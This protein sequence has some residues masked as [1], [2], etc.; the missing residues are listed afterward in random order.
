MHLFAYSASKGNTEFKFFST[1]FLHWLKKLGAKL[2]D[3]QKPARFSPC[4]FVPPF[5]FND[6][7]TI[8]EIIWIEDVYNVTGR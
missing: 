6:A 5:I 1:Y 2:S 7:L 4:L 3:F 8:S